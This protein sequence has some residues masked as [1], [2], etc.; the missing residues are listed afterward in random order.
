MSKERQDAYVARE[1]DRAAKGYDESRLVKSFQRRTQ[2]LVISGMRIERGMSI[3][4]LGCGTGSGTLDIASGLEG[5]GRVIGLDLS[6][7]MIEQAR[8]KLAGFAYDNVEFQVG[9]GSTLDYEDCFDYAVSTNAFHHFDK[10]EEVFSRVW[11]SL[12]RN[13]VF[14]VEDICDDY[15]LMRVVDFAGK[16]GERAHVG[17][18]TSRALRGLFLSTGFVDVEVERT[19]LNSFWRVMIG[20][21]TKQANDA[22]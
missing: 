15:V 5:T 13:G 14:V 22:G 9:S 6:E 7:K 3:L 18:C 8:R 21:G 12:R 4:D 16:L 10:K 2:A 17:S 19:K 11:R 20:R 1:F